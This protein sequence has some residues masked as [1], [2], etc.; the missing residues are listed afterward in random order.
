MRGAGTR[1]ARLALVAVALLLGGCGDR[2]GGEIETSRNAPPPS[3]GASA[4]RDSFADGHRREDA[5]E[6]TQVAFVGSIQNCSTLSQWTATAKSL[7]V[8]LGGREPNFV[9][10]VC[11]AADSQTQAL[12]ICRE[13]TA[14]LQHRASQP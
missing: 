13:A 6:N 14:V 3:P 4:C 7:G 12:A 1:R 5:G 2:G 9:E 10:S 11:S 8:D